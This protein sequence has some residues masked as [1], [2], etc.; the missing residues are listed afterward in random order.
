VLQEFPRLVHLGVDVVLAGFGT[1]AYFL[2]LLLVG[3]ILGL[4]V[5][6]L[7]PKFAEVHDLADWWSFR[8][9]DLDQVQLGFP[10]QLH[11]LG[12]RHHSELFAV[13]ANQADGADA[14]LF[15]DS[16]VP[17]GLRVTVVDT[18]DSFL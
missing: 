14:D 6:L 2:E 1:N 10:G 9:S 4:L 13:D 12:G 18:R 11:G 7:I 16:L 3:P 17:F 5:G 8:G 15:I